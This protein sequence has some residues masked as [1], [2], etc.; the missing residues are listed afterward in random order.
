[1]PETRPDGPT[2]RD[3]LTRGAAVTAAAA[4]PLAAART[5]WAAGDDTLRVGV[6]GC[7]GRGTGAAKDCLNAHPSV[8]VVALADLFPDRVNAARNGLAKEFKG[9][10]AVAE[11]HTFTGFDAFQKLLKTDIDLVLLASPPGFRPKHFEAAVAAGKHVFM[12]KPVAVDATGARRV[13][14]AADAADGKSLSVVAGTQ[15]RHHAGYVQTIKRLHDG[16]IGEPVAAQCYWMQGGLWHGRAAGNWKKHRAGGYDDT[17][18]QIRN[19]LFSGWLSGDHIVEQHVHNI[20]IINWVMGGPPKSATG[21][22]G[23]LQRTDPMFGN[24]YDHFAIEYVYPNEARCLSM[25][26]QIDGTSHK[27]WERVTGTK[28]WAAPGGRIEGEH[29]WRFEGDAP[30]PYVQEHKDL[31][32]SIRGEHASGG[33]LNEAKRIAESSLTA[34]LGRTAAYAGRELSWDWIT[35]SKLDLVPDNVTFGD[36]DLA[37]VPIPGEY[38]LV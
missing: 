32:A 5:A 3:V 13:I 18:W 9:R 35:K 26:R 2:R 22:G 11:E 30:N 29:A 7:G 27:V 20:D 37:P 28:G 17:E 10:A 8:R 33:R 6:I 24:I 14:A 21:V 1:M 25:C 15:R 16:A 34:I 36:R 31:I 4:V 38:Q 12:E 19:W 23:R